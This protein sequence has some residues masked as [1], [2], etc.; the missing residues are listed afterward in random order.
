MHA[1]V[2][3]SQVA[4]L[5]RQ[6]PE[7]S[8]QPH[9]SGSKN[10]LGISAGFMLDER[11]PPTYGLWHQTA[12]KPSCVVPP[13]PSLQPEYC[14]ILQCAPG[15]GQLVSLQT[16]WPGDVGGRWGGRGGL[17]AAGTACPQPG[18]WGGSEGLAPKEPCREG[19]GRSD[20]EGGRELLLQ[21]AWAQVDGAWRGFG[22]EMLLAREVI[23]LARG[24][25][26]GDHGEMLDGM[27]GGGGVR[28]GSCQDNAAV[29]A[30]ALLVLP[31]PF[32]FEEQL[33]LKTN[34]QHPPRTG[35]DPK[36]QDRLQGA[37]RS[38]PCPIKCHSGTQLE[39]ARSWLLPTSDPLGFPCSPA[40]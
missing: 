21:G 14:R 38:F 31:A 22:A 39:G 30:A 6:P 27:R 11:T 24:F 16:P 10:T 7:S 29:L 15:Q 26:R 32:N 1:E 40:R 9:A 12:Q 35:Y 17:G 8:A 4:P 3:A 25:T 28:A 18:Y 23:F 37:C 13:V 36:P 20:A 19:C 34:P 2:S 5:L 33:H